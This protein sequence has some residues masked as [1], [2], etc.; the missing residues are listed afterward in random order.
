MYISIKNQLS[1]RNERL[2]LNF[3]Q[4]RQ[5][6]TEDKSKNQRSVKMEIV[7]KIEEIITIKAHGKTENYVNAARKA[8]LT[9]KTVVIS[10]Q[11][12]T[13]IKAVSVAE[14]LKRTME[15]EKRP[16]L[17]QQ[18]SIFNTEIGGK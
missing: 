12:K 9:G 17:D 2:S 15:A 7:S 10:G 13:L 14:V 16:G 11:D 6:F 3:Y 1:L 8:L 4:F 5:F 18:N